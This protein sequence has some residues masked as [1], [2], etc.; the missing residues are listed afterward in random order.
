MKAKFFKTRQTILF[1]L[2]L[3]LLG[4]G[5]AENDVRLRHR[6]PKAPRIVLWAWERPEDLAFVDAGTTGIAFLA[7]TIRIKDNSAVMLEARRQ[8]L[9]VPDLSS[10]IAVVR[11]EP[12][13]MSKRSLSPA[14]KADAAAAICRLVESFKVSQVQ[15]DFDAQ[16]SE[17][18]FYREL[19]EEL[20]R[21]LP[22]T[23]ALTMTALASWCVHDAWMSN[24][25]VDEA[26]PM[27]FRMGP[28]ARQ[29]VR[30]LENT[31]DFRAPICGTSIG[32]SSDELSVRAPAGKRLYIFSPTPWTKNQVETVLREVGR[33]Q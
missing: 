13:R 1:I 22:G 18:I 23:V 21:R 8:P 7:G 12:D 11:V 27:L 2:L 24:L 16:L 10:L 9:R 17:R 14:L 31:G 30:Y 4:L 29:I 20:R 15:I 25:P 6:Q 26:V 3:S 5:A 33:W 28:E 19:L 32:I